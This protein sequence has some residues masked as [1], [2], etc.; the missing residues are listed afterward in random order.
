[1]DNAEITAL[2]PK[3]CLPPR[4]NARYI[5]FLYIPCYFLSMLKTRCT[6][7]W[8]CFV[9]EGKNVF[10]RNGIVFNLFLKSPIVWTLRTR[11]QVHKLFDS[12]LDT[13]QKFFSGYATKQ[14]YI[15]SFWT[16]GMYS[17]AVLQLNTFVLLI[18]K[19]R[20]ICSEE[21]R[22]SLPCHDKELHGWVQF[23]PMKAHHTRPPVQT[24]TIMFQ[25][26]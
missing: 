5:S 19:N 7:L 26:C 21:E 24:N 13:Q 20:T 23:G 17:L 8:G 10:L 2:S 11:K 3:T 25:I 6:D 12:Y 9:I 18:S 15:L 1:M 16:E 22:W 14:R 4:G